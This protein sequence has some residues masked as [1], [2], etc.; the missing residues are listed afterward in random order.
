MLYPQKSPSSFSPRCVN[1]AD[2]E[3]F[4]LAPKSM[5]VSTCG[6]YSDYGSQDPT[7]R[8]NTGGTSKANSSSNSGSTLSSARGKR[9]PQLLQEATI[10]IY[11][12][13]SWNHSMSTL[14]K[15]VWG[16]QIGRSL[17]IKQSYHVLTCLGYMA[18]WLH[19]IVASH[20][21]KTSKPC[22]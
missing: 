18:T 19:P 11:A 6:D 20:C 17:K 14:T 21:D 5:F 16:H 22:S 15:N 3:A 1:L 2:A 7:V 12:K 13:V 10:K 8:K 4:G 9:G